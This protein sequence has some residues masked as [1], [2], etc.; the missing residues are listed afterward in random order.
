MKEK[1][2]VLEE[3]TLNTFMGLGRQAW[4][5][6]RARLKDL[7]STSNPTLRDN[8]ELR[9]VALIERSKCHMHLPANIGDYTDFYS[10]RQH[11]TNVG[12]MFRGIENALM[13][14]W[15]HL[16]VGY[17][18]RSS[19]V[20]VSGT[21]FKRPYGQMRPDDA[22]PPVF[23]PCKLVDFELEMAFFVGPGNKLGEPISIDKAHDHI[24]GMV[25]MND[26]SA[27]DIQKWEYVPLGPFTAKNFCT[28][29][30]PWIVTV[31]YLRC[32]E[33]FKH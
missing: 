17:H 13:L 22:Q 23:G 31:S 24:F 9:K 3:S 26:W 16:P 28:S 6:V 10:S 11:A 32:L 1:Q 21:D 14:N 8:Q 19:S 30:S 12:T 4:T 20:V 2:S 27:R 15:L 7:L 18:G 33:M 29:I 5:E 25:L